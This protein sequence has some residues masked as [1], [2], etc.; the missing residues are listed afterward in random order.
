MK[1]LWG[2]YLKPTPKNVAKILLGIKAIL[3][4]VAGTEMA[5]GNSKLAFWLVV[6]IGVIHE[7][8]TYLTTDE[9]TNN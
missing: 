8:T 6:S 3:G 5:M 2:N 4:T 9:N 7:I 1:K